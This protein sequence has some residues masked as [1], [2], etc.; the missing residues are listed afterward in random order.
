MTRHMGAFLAVAIALAAPALRSQAA[1]DSPGVRNWA[2]DQVKAWTFHRKDNQGH[3]I[4]TPLKF[5]DL[6]YEEQNAQLLDRLAGNPLE[7]RAALAL[8]ATR[9]ME[10]WVR[11]GLRR[12]ACRDEVAAWAYRHGF[13][14]DGKDPYGYLEPSARL[15][16]P[17]TQGLGLHLDGPSWR[18]QWIP[19]PALLA[20]KT[21]GGA[22]PG[23]LQTA[24]VPT[25][26]MHFRQLRPGLARLRDL[27]GG[28]EG[29]V[30]T[31]AHGTRAGFLLRH[32]G[33]WLKEAPAGLEPLAGKEAWVLHY[34]LPK[35]FGPSAGTLVFL[36]GDLPARTTLALGLLKLNP[37]SA[38]AR[39]RSQ[40]W[41]D[42]R[43]GK[44]QITQVRGSGGVL[45]LLA[46]PEGTWLC[47]RE[48]PLR[49]VALPWAFTALG[50]R[51]EW[52][53]VA[54]AAL[55]PDTDASIWILPRLGA[56]AAF[57]R[58]ALRRRLLGVDAPTWANPSIA[59]AAP[60][61]GVLSAALGAG[62]TEVLLNAI[63]R[64]DREALPT[65]PPLPDGPL[66]ATPEQR[67]AYDREAAALAERRRSLASLNTDL[68]ALQGL[69][70]LRGAA[71]LWNGWTA[72]S[73]LT[74]AQRA[75]L[76]DF[77]KLRRADPVKAAQLE[78]HRRIDVYGGFLEPGM[79]PGIAL[80]LPVLAGKGPQA[81]ER[82]RALWPRLFKG[83]GQNQD[84]AKGVT[85]HRVL[86]D[87]A[88]RPS[89][90][91][92]ADTLVVAT[93]DAAAQAMLAGLL[94]QAPSLADRSSTAYGRLEMDGP[95]AARD[96][97][98][99]LLSYLRANQ[100]G[101]YWWLGEPEPTGDD[102]SAE[103][104]ATFGPFLG[105]LRGLGRQELDVDLTAAGFEARRR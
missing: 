19:A 16:R 36:P 101:R 12:T 49:A 28:E 54:L 2:W 10:Q 65:L 21:E 33:P 27:A 76:A 90:A 75:I 3:A 43:G 31:L 50:E 103:V 68:A 70:D 60:R 99:L 35:G 88:F 42:G 71:F 100:E 91:F 82:L 15:D 92:A 89:Y 11:P 64:L 34:G 9:P 18:F 32:L 98:F 57:E 25:V 96:L 77:Q 29:V 80:A 53:K 51:Q 84:Y 26:L 38:G 97:E 55:R 72:P 78:R 44:A 4:W 93:D 22:L 45:H 81:E 14:L 102:A 74:P 46:V 5:L 79:S 6:T 58:A 13:K 66:K 7:R 47:D 94:G 30:D 41:E 87:Q 62:P 69:L 63:L 23:P 1:L 20:F 73:P 52:C 24:P 8:L 104:A 39:S 83:P 67:R 61:G 59:K 85:L 37:T 56:G 86:T 17:W 40:T 95:R 48:D 105:A